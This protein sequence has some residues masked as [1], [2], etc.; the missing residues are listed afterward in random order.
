VDERS[1]DLLREL[2][3]LNDAEIRANAWR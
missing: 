1:K 3:E 2:A